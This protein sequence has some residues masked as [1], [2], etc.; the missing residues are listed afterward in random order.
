MRHDVNSPLNEARS[1]SAAVVLPVPPLALARVMTVFS[2]MVRMTLRRDRCGRGNTIAE[3]SQ[4]TASG[5]GGTS[6]RIASGVGP[7]RARCDLSN[8]WTAGR[9]G[10]QGF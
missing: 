6:V 8:H 4:A 2:M 10:T 9:Q 7:S 1:E 3:H 5:R